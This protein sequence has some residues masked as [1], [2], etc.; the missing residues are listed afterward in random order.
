MEKKW[1]E[2]TP[3]EKRAGRLQRWLDA[4][5]VKFASKK[6]EA[7]YK[8]RVQRFIDVIN[9]REPDRVPVSL[10]AGFFAAFYSGGSLEKSMYDYR[11][12]GRAWKKFMRDFEHDS[13][14]GPGLVLPGKA[15]D[16]IDYKIHKWPGHGLPHDSAIYQYVE[17][18]YMKPE[19]YADLLRDPSDFW[20]RTYLP[21]IA[22]AF[23]PFRN[24]A[25]MSA[26][27]SI[28]LGLLGSFGRPDVQKAFKSLI[29][30]GTETAKWSRVVKSVSDAALKSGIPA[31]GGGISGAPF[32]MIADMHRG[33][34]GAIM[35]M[36]RRPEVLI[37]AME[38]ITPIAIKQAVDGANHSLSPIVSM[39]LHKGD[40]SFMSDK[41]F[42]KF[43]WPTFR[44]VLMGLINEG[45]VPMPFAEGS[46]MRRLEVIKDLPKGSIIWYFE[47]TDLGKAKEV[48]GGQAC[49]AG[50]VP[51]SVLCTGTPAEVKEV[52]R[53]Q[54][55][56]GGKG[57]GYILAGG[58]SMNKGNPDNLRAMTE[59]AREYG[60]YKK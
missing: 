5:E 45:L 59:A 3:E 48:L 57:G 39:P 41:Q 52:C 1:E 22:G 9:L 18:E 47:R 30:A 46:Y 20:W 15:I 19:E 51:V 17:G 49:I 13:F 12:L 27:I 7:A 58:A 44:K 25:P 34:A 40:D 38:K 50:N 4:P 14:G 32:D 24:L 8:V 11:E 35:D 42:E 10:P 28:P 23:E 6:A 36:Y 33:T 56:I 55:A 43:Y 16:L 21:R 31:F 2:M 37:E 26:M 54:I 53:Q 29:A 60:V